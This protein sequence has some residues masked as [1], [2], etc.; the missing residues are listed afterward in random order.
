MKTVLSYLRP[1]ARRVAVGISIKFTAAILELALPLLLAHIIDDCVPAGDLGA[2]RRAGLG[3]MVLAFGAAFCNIT[4]N[5]MAAW[6]S[7]EMTRDLRRDLYRR[8]QSLSCAQA[9]RISLS[10]LV[11]RLT[12]DTYNVHQMFDKIQRGGIRAPMLVLGGLTLT[13]LQAP[14]LGLVQLG[15]CGLTFLAIALVTRRGIPHYT[16]AQEAVDTVVRILREN[17][18]GVRV[19]KAMACQGR[20][21]G[22]F[23][24]ASRAAQRAEE[25]A[26]GIMAAANP[27]SDFLLNTGLVLVVA[28]GAVLVNAGWLASGQ[29]VAFLSYFTLIQTATLGLAKLFVKLSKGVASARRIEEILLAPEDQPARPGVGRDGPE[30]GM[31]RVSFSYL[32][33]EQDLEDASFTLNKGETLGILGPT[34]AGKTTLIS[35]LLRLYDAGEGVVWVGGRDVAGLDR[36]ALGSR[37]GVVFQNEALLND[38]VYENI[39]FLRS[40]PRED[41]EAAAGTAQIGDFIRSLPEG[42]DTRV[43]IRGANLSGG[44]RQRL[45]IA[46][47]LAA[48]PGVLILDSADSALDYRT[49]A[50][51]YAALRRD[52]PG[53][54]LV[55]VSERVAALQ[56]ADRILVL[57]EGRIAAQGSHAQLLKTNQRYRKMAE[58]QMGGGLT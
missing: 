15:A 27:L 56:E 23:E 25:T 16:R 36:T 29:I 12:N 26:G 31:E 17:A 6:V 20:E 37:F 35:L 5:R 53:V 22:R 30:L 28:A 46:R 55:V 38:S 41:V 4:A 43:D 51:L 54:T 1:H 49:A 21:R 14:L 42:L 11:S 13:A 58:L 52:F 44:Q 33:M 9:D 8:A 32:G 19:I 18:S 57:E 45:L 47:A 50:N 3:M 39:S 10:S 2:I 7:M 24:E 48:R 40:L 34:G